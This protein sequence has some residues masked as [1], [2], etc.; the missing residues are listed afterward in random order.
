MHIQEVTIIY[1]GHSGLVVQ[2]LQRYV[3][4]LFR[5]PQL[6]LG[7]CY[8]S[9]YLSS[10]ERM[11]QINKEPVAFPDKF[12]GGRCPLREKKENEVKENV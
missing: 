4:I 2:L 5:L 1:V 6:H 10:N 3:A 7:H 8:L 12:V 9:P 11:C